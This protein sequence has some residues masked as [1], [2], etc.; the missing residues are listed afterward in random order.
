M[1]DISTNLPTALAE[2]VDRFL[3]HNNIELTDSAKWAIGLSDFVAKVAQSQKDW[4]SSAIIDGSLDEYAAD[5]G[6]PD[7]VDQ[8]LGDVEDMNDLKHILRKL[9]DRRQ[10]WVIWRHI[11]GLASFEETTT[12][13]TRLAEILINA[14]LVIVENRERNRQG[15][16]IGEKSG[17]EQ[18]MVV[19]GLGKLGGQELNLSSDVDLIF[20]FSEPG[21][22]S[23]GQ[24]SQNFFIRVG[25][26]L[27][28]ALHTVTRDGFVFRVDMRLRAYGTSGPLAMHFPAMRRYLETEGRD[29]ERYA[30]IKARPIAG[31]IEAGQEFLESVQP[32]VYRKYMD[33]G[34]IESMRDIKALQDNRRDADDI[35]LG[36]GGIRDAEFTVQVQQLIRAGRQPSLR[37]PTFLNALAELGKIELFDEDTVEQLEAAYR[38][39]RH[40]EHSVQ[41][42]A[43]RQTQ[44]LPANDLGR[45]RLSLS[46][47][48][49]S[50]DQYMVELGRHRTNVEVIFDQLL[51][52]DEPEV[53]EN[54]WESRDN[55]EAFRIAGFANP[56]KVTQELNNLENARDR[57]SVSDSARK[58]LNELM[59]R[60]LDAVARST[61]PDNKIINLIPILR[62]V[63][64]RS[65]YLA[66]LR[67]NPSAMQRFIRLA[68]NSKWLAEQFRMRPMFIDMLHDSSISI[69]AN[70]PPERHELIE[71]LGDRLKSDFDEETILNELREFKER[72]VFHVV[73]GQSLGLLPLMLASDYLTFLAEAMLEHALKL[74]W[75]SLHARYSEELSKSRDAFVVVG[76]GKLGG[77]ELSP[78]SD[79]DLV[80]IHN[81]SNETVPFIHRLV[82]RLLS[83]LT[84]RT[85]FGAL[86]EIDMRLR[87]SGKAGPMVTSLS[88][89]EHYQ[90]QEAEVWEHQSLV[91]ARA[92]AGDA[93]LCEQFEKVRRNILCKKRDQEFLREEILKMRNRMTDHHDADEDIKLG[94]GGVVDIEFMVQFIVLAFA[95]QYPEL[96]TYSDNIRI[97][98]IAGD[99]EVLDRDD[100]DQLTWAYTALRS[101]MHQHMMDMS[102][103]HLD[104]D[105][106]NS[107]RKTVNRIWEQLF[108]S[109]R[110]GK[111]KKYQNSEKDKVD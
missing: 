51:V 110:I 62:D 60:F 20:A 80:F 40:S 21:K 27:I 61:D 57:Q 10:C 41:A 23:S 74:S 3:S 4:F 17:K 9:R 18:R 103:T 89:F 25:Q 28:D 64:G 1:I 35:K 55:P 37:V 34:S 106:M 38:F 87:P 82:R 33:F 50:Y 97:L 107:Y 31:D 43:D 71:A 105:I 39:F 108:D 68:G 85:Y 73:L 81:M 30:Y 14:A 2:R 84:S 109:P 52:I 42:E 92:V 94:V 95:N 96:T 8:L 86:Y 98:E 72:H 58:R 48:Y 83:I 6:L 45:L 16:P 22:T 15:I 78:G 79:L 63:L 70:P 99:C 49:T 5:W 53:S 46:H 91:R 11:L 76:Y 59:P 65:T 44:R 104:E 26:R 13:A 100:A 93:E 66:F 29:W 69:L 47:G 111:Q 67:D 12:S 90:N 7:E 75:Q 32:F 19:F 56:E 101:Q 36:V 54:L 24:N 102:D 88:G 77:I